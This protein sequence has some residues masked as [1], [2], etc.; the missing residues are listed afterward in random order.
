MAETKRGEDAVKSLDEEVKVLGD[1][2]EQIDS[3]TSSSSTTTLAG[4][5]SKDSKLGNLFGKKIRINCMDGYIET[6][7]DEHMARFDYLCTCLSS[8]DFKFEAPFLDYKKEDVVVFIY[9]TKNKTTADLSK[10]HKKMVNDLNE[11]LQKDFNAFEEFK[12]LKE[13]VLNQMVEMTIKA[14]IKTKVY[15]S[16]GRNLMDIKCDASLISNIKVVMKA[17]ESIFSRY[18]WFT[19]KEEKLSLEIL[20]C[21]ELNKLVKNNADIIEFSYLLVEKDGW[22]TYV[23]VMCR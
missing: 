13:V 14:M 8:T 6:I 11:Y 4:S 5:R 17:E 3:K 21:C 2:K 19:S 7:F 22:H 23:N 20:Y 16:Y 15:D 1:G 12:R 9:W 10:D 18:N